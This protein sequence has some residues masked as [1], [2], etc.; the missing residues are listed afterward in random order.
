MALGF[1]A[2]V[3]MAGVYWVAKNPP[4]F[5]DVHQNL[6]KSVPAVPEQ[7]RAG[8]GP[9]G[10]EEGFLVLRLRAAAELTDAAATPL[11]EGEIENRGFA[12]SCDGKVVTLNMRAQDQGKSGSEEG[13]VA[14]VDTVVCLPAQKE[15]KGETVAADTMAEIAPQMEEEE[16][17]V[18][19]KASVAGAARAKVIDTGRGVYQVFIG[20][21]SFSGC[22]A[23]CDAPKPWGTAAQVGVAKVSHALDNE[24]Y[25]FTVPAGNAGSVSLNAAVPVEK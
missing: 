15:V 22:A 24:N 4:N 3:G 7:F 6:P 10:L 2:A 11:F 14:E 12:T 17:Q 9:A 21:V 25:L 5:K 8:V 20:A 18:Y 13:A 19:D 1:V 23:Q 16:K